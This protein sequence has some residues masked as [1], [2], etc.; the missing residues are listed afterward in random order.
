MSQKSDPE[1]SVGA[2]ASFVAQSRTELRSAVDTCMARSTSTVH[3]TPKTAHFP[4]VLST[5]LQD[6]GLCA[7]THDHGDYLSL[8]G[9]LIP[10]QGRFQI[11]GATHCC[12]IRPHFLASKKKGAIYSSKIS[13]PGACLHLHTLVRIDVRKL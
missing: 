10:M 5:L 4:E 11:I 3:R 12:Y 8:V 9:K 2:V 1:F 13:G 7:H 6:D